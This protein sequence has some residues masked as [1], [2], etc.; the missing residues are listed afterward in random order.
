MANRHLP[1]DLPNTHDELTTTAFSAIQSLPPNR[2]A[3]LLLD[4]SISLIAAGQFVL[5]LSVHF[6]GPFAECGMNR[7][8]AEVENFLEVYLR[9]PNLDKCDIARALVARGNAR[10]AAG[11]ILLGKAR[12]GTASVFNS[13]TAIS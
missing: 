11:D 7:Y 1:P 12:Q 4:T 2:K 3:S 13:V 5:V 10:K 9:T 8:G 6:P